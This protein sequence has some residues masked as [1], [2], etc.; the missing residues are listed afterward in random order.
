MKNEILEKKIEQISTSDSLKSISGK[1]I[2]NKTGTKGIAESSNI[3]NT[4]SVSKNPSNGTNGM[5]QKGEDYSQETRIKCIIRNYKNLHAKFNKVKDLFIQLIS[6]YEEYNKQS[7]MKSSS[8][9]GE[10]I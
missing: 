8:K 7:S 1:N 4:S 6:I 10:N 5:I 9:E 3:P 2:N